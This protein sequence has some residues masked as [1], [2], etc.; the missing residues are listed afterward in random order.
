MNNDNTKVQDLSMYVMLELFN[1]IRETTH[2]K[3]L[4]EP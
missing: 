2:G 4:R 1:E 3:N